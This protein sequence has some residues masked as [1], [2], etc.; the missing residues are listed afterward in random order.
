M[1]I[2]PLTSRQRVVLLF[3]GL[4]FCILVVF[5]ALLFVTSEQHWQ[6]EKEISLERTFRDIRTFSDAV[7]TL[8]DILVLDPSGAV[9]HSQGF[10]S[11]LTDPSDVLDKSIYR[12]RDWSYFLV[13]NIDPKG[14]IL[15]FAV[16]VTDLVNQ[17]ERFLYDMNSF[18]LFALA[19]I[20]FVALAFTY[21]LYEP[22]RD[23]YRSARAFMPRE[24]LA[25]QLVRVE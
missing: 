3:T 23:I 7:D 19:A 6:R 14:N 15:V 9:L 13:E 25:P 20:F 2:F 18:S 11:S 12:Y 22:I 5:N 21:I 10:F 16:D 24:P 4:V 8:D 1:V 17:R